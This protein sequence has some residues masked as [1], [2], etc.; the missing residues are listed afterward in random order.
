[1]VTYTQITEDIHL[2]SVNRRLKIDTIC[3]HL[4]AI[5]LY[6]TKQT[7]KCC[8]FVISNNKSFI[9]QIQKA[10]AS[11]GGKIDRDLK[12]KNRF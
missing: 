4:L 5:T 8:I 11:L 9:Y 3:C 10:V 12:F 2:N 6:A 7:V 1:M